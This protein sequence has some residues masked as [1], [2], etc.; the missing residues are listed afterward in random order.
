MTGASTKTHCKTD[1]CNRDVSARGMCKLHYSRW[2]RANQPD[3]R[4]DNC[5]KTAHSRGLCY[6]HYRR[7]RDAERGEP[8]TVKACDRYASMTG[9][10]TGHYSRKWYRENVGPGYRD[11]EDPIDAGPQTY[12]S[13]HKHIKYVHGSASALDCVDCG[14]AAEDWSYNHDG[15]NSEV[16]DDAIGLAYSTDI[17]DY[18]PRCKPCHGRFDSRCEVA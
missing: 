2:R 13:M 12:Y 8:C 10:C 16:I 5:D 11:M 18:D 14:Q 7:M 1:Q 6:Y 4:Q 3:C 15:G 17:G 9:L